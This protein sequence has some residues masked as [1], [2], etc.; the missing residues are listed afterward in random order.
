MRASRTR[1]DTTLYCPLLL[2]GEQGGGKQ[3]RL[4]RRG[5]AGR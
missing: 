1:F 4:A 5:E 2:P 3:E